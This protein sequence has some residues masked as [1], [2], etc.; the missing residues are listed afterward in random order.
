MSVFGNFSWDFLSKT[1]Y[2]AGDI[3]EK[4]IVYSPCFLSH[5]K[6]NKDLSFGFVHLLGFTFVFHFIEVANW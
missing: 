2:Y 5:E 3:T 1:K 6:L 4:Q